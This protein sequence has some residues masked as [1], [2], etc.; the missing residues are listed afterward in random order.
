MSHIVNQNML[1]K[2]L[3]SG[4]KG[5]ARTKR[6]QQYNR[7]DYSLKVLRV[8]ADTELRHLKHHSKKQLISERPWTNESQAEDRKSTLKRQGD[9]V[10]FASSKVP[11]D[12][13]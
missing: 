11:G 9:S 3:H 6:R 10:V 8:R 12:Q 2:V 13:D 5:R 7:D 4:K 1:K